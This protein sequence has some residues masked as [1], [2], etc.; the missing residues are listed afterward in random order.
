MNLLR[1]II[2]RKILSLIKFYHIYHSLHRHS[3]SENGFSKNFQGEANPWITFPCIEFLRTLDLSSARVFEF[4][5]GSSTLFWSK[6][7]LEVC[8]I[9]REREWFQK[10]SSSVAANVT[11]KH[12]PDERNYFKMIDLF[13]GD[14]DILVIDGAVRF[15]SLEYSL[16]RLSNRGFVILDNTEWYPNC[17]KLLREQGYTQIDFTGFPPINAFTSCTSLF[18]KNSELINNKKNLEKWTPIG[19]RHLIAHDDVPFDKINPD[20]LVER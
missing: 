7:C 4:G 9:E 20:T 16:P 12:S 14:F 18:F 19:G 6:H 1:K 11:L 2:P 8:S 13:S 5:S 17:A 10:V 3:S 15:P